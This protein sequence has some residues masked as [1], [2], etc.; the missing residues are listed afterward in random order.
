MCQW[1]KK[2][3]IVP[4]LKKYPKHK[5]EDFNWL[6]VQCTEDNQIDFEELHNNNNN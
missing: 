6:R 1:C 5:P 4:A 3:I 2:S